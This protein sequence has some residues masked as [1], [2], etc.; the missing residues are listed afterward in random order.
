MLKG[1][2]LLNEHCAEVGVYLTYTINRCPAKILKNM[3]H[4]EAWS[5]RKYS[6]THIRV[7]RCEF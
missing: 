3:I 5:G 6:V 2:C 7:F 4:E 1:K